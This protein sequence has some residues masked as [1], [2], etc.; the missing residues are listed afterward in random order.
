[1]SELADIQRAYREAHARMAALLEEMQR[2]EYDYIIRHGI[3]APDGSTLQSISDIEVE[4]IFEQAVTGYTAE[5]EASGLAGRSQAARTILEEA[6]DALVQFALAQLPHEL[7]AVT[8]Y[9]AQYNAAF[10]QRMIDL[11]LRLDATAMQEK[12]NEEFTR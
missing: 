5:I 7:R 4:D 11:T 9:K 2:M 8:E 6:G 12:E 3:T 1:M 10:R